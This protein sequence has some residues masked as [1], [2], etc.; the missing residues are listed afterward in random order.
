MHWLD[1]LIVGIVAWS[2]F[3]AFTN[4]LIREVVQFAAVV[5]GLLLAGLFYNDLS[6]DIEFLVEHATTRNLVSF[7]AIFAGIV[8]LGQVAAAVLRRFASLLMLGPVDHLG[9]AAFGFVKAVLLVQVVLIAVAVFPPGEALAKAV[10]DSTLAP[11]FLQDLPVAQ[12]AL[13]VE[14]GDALEQLQQWRAG[15]AMPHANAGDTA[16]TT[17]P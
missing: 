10:D 3:A 14:F 6:R 12:A 2:T 16:A 8:V 13:P 4:G 7:V 17:S 9:G 1:L 11:M 15:I 5:V